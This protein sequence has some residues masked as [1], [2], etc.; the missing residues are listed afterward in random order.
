VIF[1]TALALI[2]FGTLRPFLVTALA[3]TVVQFTVGNILEPRLMGKGLNL[4]PVVMLLGLAVWGTI[5]GIVGMFLAVPLMVVSMIVFSQFH[6]TRPIAVL[7]SAD[8][9]LRI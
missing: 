6:A 7:M 3:L 9:E 8:G 2:Q 1:P 5:W 4:S